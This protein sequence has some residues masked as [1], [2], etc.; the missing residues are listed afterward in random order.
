M[1]NVQEFTYLKSKIRSQTLV[2]IDQRIAH[3]HIKMKK[4]Q[5]ILSLL[6]HEHNTNVRHSGML[7]VMY[8]IPLT[9]NMNPNILD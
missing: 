4:L 7:K 2:T 9:K 1:Q 6:D 3:G 8:K 5:A